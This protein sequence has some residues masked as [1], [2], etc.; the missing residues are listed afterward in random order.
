MEFVDSVLTGRVLKHVHRI[1]L[2]AFLNFSFFKPYMSQ[3]SPEFNNPRFSVQVCAI[4][5]SSISTISMNSD[6]AQNGVQ[7]TINMADTAI[8][9]Y[10]FANDLLTRIVIS[11]SAVNVPWVLLTAIF[12]IKENR[13]IFTAMIKI[14]TL[15]STYFNVCGQ[16][17]YNW[18]LL[19]KWSVVRLCQPKS[20]TELKQAVTS[21][22]DGI[23]TF[24]KTCLLDILC[25]HGNAM[26]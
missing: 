5:K 4:F 18:H 24:T 23:N 2:K 6:I 3:F 16:T 7:H 13:I 9:M 20:G 11:C 14:M 17:I 8:N 15:L 21:Q 12:R 25:F 10:V 19:F 26:E 1:S 22:H